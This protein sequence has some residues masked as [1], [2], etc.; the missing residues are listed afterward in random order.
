MDYKRDSKTWDKEKP[1]TN[2]NFRVRI[3]KEKFIKKDKL[4]K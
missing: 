4:Y 2:T 3:W 1:L